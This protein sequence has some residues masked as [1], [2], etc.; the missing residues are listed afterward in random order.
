M[1]LQFLGANRQVTGSRYCLEVAGAKV[2]IDCGL[3]QERAFLNRNWD[4]CPIPATGID[5]LLLTHAHLDHVGLIPR[6]VQEGFRGPIFA[7]RA[8]VRLAELILRDSA[9]IQVEDALYK[10]L[11]HQ[12]EKRTGPRPEIPL[13]TPDDVEQTLP[14]FRWQPYEKRFEVRPGIA[15]R[16]HEAGHMLG[17]AYLEINAEE[18]GVARTIVF[19]GDIGQRGKPFIRDPR[20]L[21]VADYLV[22]ESTYGD[23]EHLDGGDIGD[24]LEQI[25]NE[26][27]ARGG[28]VVIPT[29]AVERAQELMYH[30]SHLVHKNRIPDLPIFL[31]SP[32]AEDVTNIFLD[33]RD[34]Y[35]EETWARIRARMPPLKF[36][37]L[38][39]TRTSQE[40]RQINFVRGSC[41]IMATSGM[42]TAGRIKHHLRFNLPREESTIVFVGYQA[43]GTLGRQI[44]N[45]PERVRIHGREWPVRAEIRQLHGLSGHAD[46]TGLIEWAGGLNQPPRHVFLTHG[47]ATA[48]TALAQVLETEFRWKVSVPNYGEVA[49]LD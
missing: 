22:M 25:V 47:E 24:A 40:S 5:A 43:A 31:D 46:R 12:R 34:C 8:T 33:F 1:R 29:F 41:I 39:F 26:T 18:A 27:V 19:S 20:P 7:T 30:L 35:D 37:G 38:H 49:L 42:C 9:D 28:N 6:L 11:R 45:R 10:A 16:F 17:S 3:F 48:A 13:Y 23:R 32:M 14:L 2:M 44:L 21:E 15:A 4:P 36:P